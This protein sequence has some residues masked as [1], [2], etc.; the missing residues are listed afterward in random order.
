MGGLKSESLSWV[1]KLEKLR[2][3]PPDASRAEL[4]EALQSVNSHITDLQNIGDCLDLKA[5]EKVR[6]AAQGNLPSAPYALGQSNPVAQLEA[7]QQKPYILS[8]NSAKALAGLKGK[9]ND[10]PSAANAALDVTLARRLAPLKI[11]AL[12]EWVISGNPA[13]TFNPSETRK[14]TKTGKRITES[15]SK[16]G[17]LPSDLKRIIEVAVKA[18][19]EIAK[20]DGQTTAQDELRDLL[21]KGNSETQEDENSGKSPKKASGTSTHSG[22]QKAKPSMFWG[23]LLGVKFV[24]QLRSRAKKGELTTTDKVLVLLY[25]V[26][27][28]PLEWIF[29]HLGKLFKETAKDFWHWLKHTL[30]K[31][32]TQI[33]QWAIPLLII[34]A[35]IWGAGRMYQFVVAN[36]LHWME[37]KIGAMFYH[38]DV[39][40][41]PAA[42]PAAPQVVGSSE[43]EVG[44]S[45]LKPKTPN[46]SLRTTN[47]T[48]VVSYQPSIPFQPAAEDPQILEDE[49]DAIGSNSY[50]KDHSVTPDEGIPGDVAVSRMRDLADPYK[51]TMKIGREKQTL[52]SANVTT[53]GLTIN[54]KSPDLF[55]AVTGDGGSQWNVLWEDI[56]AIHV[57]EIVS[58]TNGP[59]TYFQISAIADGAKIPFTLQCST[60]ANLQHLVSAL[61]YFIRA[62]R[63]GHDTALGGMPYSFQGVVLKNDCTADKLWANSPM[64][65]AG[66]RLGDHLWS[67]GT[68]GSQQADRNALET[69]LS[70]QMPI[71][72]YVVSPA[73]WDKAAAARASGQSIGFRPRLRKVSL[74]AS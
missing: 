20:G 74:S 22:S 63:L 55:H 41:E 43:L 27:G 4:K 50:V 10:L 12:V 73:E 16:A 24:S 37:Y 26:V 23:M 35:L 39:T 38:S 31:T 19:A 52:L 51:Y 69:G 40:S 5:I 29:K 44:S 17:T 8:F 9:V 28:K 65:K 58:E 2:A 72:L 11:T 36:P 14:K 67:I 54:Y 7:S 71:T 1:D 70:A 66:V 13:E 34:C 53:T 33:I 60:T 15:Q 59:V 61:E 25:W 18:D 30:G 68:V 6:L 56:K 21:N 57:S 46:S 64:D 48:P 32:F 45:N 3:Q 42:A 47:S 62:S 49:I